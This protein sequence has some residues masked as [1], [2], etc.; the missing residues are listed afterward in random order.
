MAA[1]TT[2]LNDFIMPAAKASRPSG[3]VSRPGLVARLAA[4]IGDVGARRAENDI[5]DFITRNGGH[6]TDELERRI[7]H[8]SM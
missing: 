1:V 8:R 6:L 5:A 3:P 4:F 7:A 2:Q